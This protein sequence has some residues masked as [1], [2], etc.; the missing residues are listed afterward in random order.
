MIFGDSTSQAFGNNFDVTIDYIRLD[1]GNSYLPPGADADGDGMSDLYEDTYFGGL[2]NGVA[3]GHDDS[4]SF[5]NLE[6][7]I[8][9]THPLDGNSFFGIDTFTETTADTWSITVPDTSPQ[10]NYTL[11]KSSD[12][13]LSN[14]WSAVSGQGPVAGNGSDLVFTDTSVSGPSQFYRVEVAIP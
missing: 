3:G 1:N 13:V 6:E 12:L 7:Y 10:R 4:D 2:T 14:S 5:T 8:A 9:D 11:Q